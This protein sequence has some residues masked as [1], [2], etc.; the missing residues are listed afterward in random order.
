MSK[1]KIV[2][3]INLIYSKVFKINLIILHMSSPPPPFLVGFAL[4]DL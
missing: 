2:L 3:V 4:L 1:S